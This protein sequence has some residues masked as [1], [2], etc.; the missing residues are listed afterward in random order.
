MSK[1]ISSGYLIISEPYDFDRG[2]KSVRRSLDE[3]TLRTNVNDLGFKITTKTKNPSYLP[4]NL[5][6]NSRAT[7]NYKVDLVIGKK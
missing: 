6:L 5:K 2:T 7:L 3:Y 1:Q 4:W